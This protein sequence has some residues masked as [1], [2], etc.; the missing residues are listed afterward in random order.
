MIEDERPNPDAILKQVTQQNRQKTGKLRVFFGYAAGVGKTYAMLRDAHEQ[1]LQGKKI[2]AGYVEPHVRPETLALLEGIPTIPVKQVSYKKM[3]L[4][5]FDLDEALRLKPDIVLV[6]ELAHTNVIG[7][8]NKKRYQDIDELLHAGIDVYTTVNVQHIESL[9]DVVES[10]THVQVVETVPDT[11]L[12]QA[13]L[14]LIDIEPEE[15]L[16]RLRAG[17]IYR[18]LQAKKAMQHFFALENLKLLREIAVRRA[19]DHIGMTNPIEEVSVRVKLLTYLDEEH[20]Q[21]T[22]KCL[23]WT[24]RLAAAFR[25]EWTLLVIENEEDEHDDLMREQRC[26]VMKLAQ[27]L[28]ADIVTLSGHDT[29]DTLTHYAK[30]TGVTDIIIAK[31]RNHSHV[32]R[33]FKQE[34]EDDLIQRLPQVDLHIIPYHDKREGQKRNRLNHINFIQRHFSAADFIKMLFY[35]LVATLLSKIVLLMHSGDQNVII[36]YL[37]F[38]LIISRVTHGYFYGA[39]ASVISVLLFNWLFVDPLYSLTVY[40]PGYPVTMVIMLL[41]ALFTSNMMI[42][43]KSQAKEAVRKEHRMTILYELNQQLL[44]NQSLAGMMAIANTKVM[45]TM[46][47]SVIFYSGLPERKSDRKL[48]VYRGDPTA[49]A[50]TT[51]EE[52]AV[53]H[54]VYLNQKFAGSGTDT[55]NG[56]AGYYFPVVSQGRSLAVIGLRV[57]P[58]R[59]L[60]RENLN[61]LKLLT[62]QLSL[63]LERHR[64]MIEQQQTVIENEKEKMRGNLL[65]AISHDLRTPLTGIL[66]ASSAIIENHEKFSAELT[67]NLVKDIK[68]DSEWLIRMVENLLSV[69]RIDEGTMKVKKTP[70]AIEE[71]VGAAVRRIRKRFKETDLTVR[72]PEE[73]LLVPMD[74][75]LIEQVLINLIENAIKHAESTAISVI[76]KQRKQ[77]V[78]FEVSDNGK[79][80][81][82]QRLETLFRPFNNEQHSEI[83][84][85]A[86]RGMGIGLSICQ[87]IVAAHGGTIEACNKTQGGAVFRFTLPIKEGD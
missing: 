17:K 78:I 86:T 52:E 51:P 9:N 71:I 23:R 31:Q 73:L 25:S 4:S 32:H 74:G 1:L 77:R 10:I 65:R 22:E 38:I 16:E 41:V 69:T 7:S 84:V 50:L 11:F 68:E 80:L 48:S 76:V 79:G 21:G 66:G 70:E 14:R 44:A 64:L 72:V 63:A 36:V 45:E 12:D 87:T 82:T 2:M 3:T 37:F 20:I 13:Y 35:I 26:K 83:P 28:G 34:L 27:S 85:D 67:L 59:P 58:E 53:A 39:L 19:A 24:A 40:K 46:G 49:A 47:R 6:D 54:W 8:R 60:H 5:E 18:P 43:V 42:R 15:L 62:S 29:L 57:N 81:P 61:F 75:T 56:A 33:L 55:L 30:M